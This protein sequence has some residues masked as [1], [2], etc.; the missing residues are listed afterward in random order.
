LDYGNCGVG[1]YNAIALT[2]FGE[3]RISYHR[4]YPAADL[5]ITR[6]ILASEFVFLPVI[7]K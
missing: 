7:L 1:E 3:P 5:M 2:P 4:A 6:L